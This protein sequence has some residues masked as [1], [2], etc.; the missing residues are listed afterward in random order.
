MDGE[1]VDASFVA[2]PCHRITDEER[3]IVKGGGIPED[4]KAKPKKL[5]QKNRASA[6][7]LCSVASEIPSSRDNC[8]TL[9][10]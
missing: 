6:R 5:A 2:A 7:H 10:S 8:R 1:I 4:W 3:E 9:S